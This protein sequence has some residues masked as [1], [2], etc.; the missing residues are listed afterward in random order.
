MSI[1]EEIAQT[2]ARNQKVEQDKTWETSR[3]RKIS[4]GIFTYIL[5]LIFLL[6]IKVENAYLAAFVPVIGFF[7]STLKVDFVR[8]IWEKKQK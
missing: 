6:V 2:R 8:K 5:A 1:E 7:L 3:I 4:V